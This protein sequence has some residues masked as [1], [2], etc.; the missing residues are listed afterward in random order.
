M[1]DDKTEIIAHFI[2][3]FELKT[4]EARLKDQYKAFAAQIAENPDLGQLLNI[5]VN[6]TSGYGLDD[7]FPYIKWPFS[8]VSV[9]VSNFSLLLPGGIG[10]APFN[11]VGFG[12]PGAFLPAVG[13][14]AAIQ[15]V[16]EIPLPSQLATVSVQYNALEDLDILNTFEGSADFIPAALLNAGLDYLQSIGD[17]LQVLRTPAPAQDED[18]IKEAGLALADDVA[19]LKEEG[20]ESDIEGATIFAAFNGDT[21]G[22]TINGERAEDMLEIGDV[23]HRFAS[24]EEEDAEEITGEAKSDSGESLSSEDQEEASH[25]VIAGSN[26]LLN[27]TTT[28]TNWLDAPVISVTGKAVSADVISQVNV[29]SDVDHINGE[30]HTPDQGTQTY[31]TAEFETEA[32]PAR[33]PI[34]EIDE[35]AEAGD[36]PDDVVVVTLEGN[37]LNYNFFQQYNFA[38]D[39]DAL[40]IS[41]SA[42]DTFLQTG[43]NTLSNAANLFGLGFHYDLI[44]VDGDSIDINYVSQ[45]NVLLDGDYLFH[46]DVFA[47]EIETSDNLLMNWGRIHTV[48]VDTF[49]TLNEDENE[50]TADAGEDLQQVDTYR[51]HDAFAELDL[52]RVLHVKGDLLKLQIVEQ[53]NVLGDGDQLEWASET[54]QSAEGANV[55]V[56]TGHN[57]LINVASIVDAGIDSSIY[58]NEGAYT[59]A[60]L[61]QADFVSEEDPLALAGMDGLASEA[62]LFLADGLLEP[63]QTEDTGIHAEAPAEVAVDIMQSMLA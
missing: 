56:N 52:L 50:A 45:T 38:Q 57:E 18:Q 33:A 44:I 53:V 60:F 54:L 32:W 12:N 36:G 22:V 40:S 48:G 20:V 34:E 27:Q 3:I 5:T 29:W 37:L 7:M 6:L 9:P 4:E 47:G 43:D 31:N 30:K 11:L 51:D 21:D 55:S 62:F 41:F 59:D 26:V 49:H 10:L 23:S 14:P 39:G 17:T 58:T 2:G 63:D 46:N 19:S 13:T 61:Y 16:F 28:F 15:T 24:S 8:F 42:H 35:D 1:L 25:E